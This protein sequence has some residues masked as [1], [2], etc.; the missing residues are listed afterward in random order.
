MLNLPQKCFSDSG[1][2]L[3]KIF[4]GY[5][6]SISIQLLEDINCFRNILFDKIIVL[7]YYYCKISNL[8]SFSEKYS[9]Y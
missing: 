7:Y 2:I 3:F 5:R 9:T 6:K 8:S 4:I 1:L